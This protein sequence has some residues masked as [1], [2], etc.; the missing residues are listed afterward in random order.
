MNFIINKKEIIMNLHSYVMYRLGVIY[1]VHGCSSDLL[2]HSVSQMH[3][4]LS[5]GGVRGTFYAICSHKCTKYFYSDHDVD[6]AATGDMC[7]HVF[8]Q[9]PAL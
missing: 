5:C 7:C 4:V 6:V 2:C 9:Y 1:V 3:Q 8:Q